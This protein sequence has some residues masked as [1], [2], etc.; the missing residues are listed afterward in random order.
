MSPHESNPSKIRSDAIAIAR[1]LRKDG[2]DW[3]YILVVLR[4][5][6]YSIMD[7]IVSV[8]SVDDVL[9]AEA[10]RLVHLSD[11]WSKHRDERDQFHEK[12]VALALDPL[13]T[14]DHAGDDAPIESRPVDKRRLPR[15]ARCTGV[16]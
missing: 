1:S 12:L 2:E 14:D 7:A 11:A 5:G 10:K 16:S 9:L 8:R 3:E 15:S 4:D 13:P 6:G